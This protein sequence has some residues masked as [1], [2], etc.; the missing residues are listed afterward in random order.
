[1]WRYL[2]RLPLYDPANIVT[3]GEGGTPLI[4]GNADLGVRLFLKDETKNPTGSMKDRAMSAAYSKAKELGIRQSVIV[5]AGGAGIAASAYAS[6]A[7]IQNTILIPKGV[8]LERT[9]TMQIYGSELIEIDGNVED[10]LAAAARMVKELGAYDATTFRRGNPFTAEAPRTIAFELYEQ[11]GEVPDVV[12][13]PVGGGGTLAGIWRGYRELRELGLTSSVPR[14]IGVQNAKFN[15]LEIA[16]ARGY[17]TDE[18]LRTLDRDIDSLLPTTTGAIKH[19]YVP[20]GVEAL[21]A[22]RDTGG[23]VATATDEEAMEGQRWI[24]RSDGL[25]VEPSSAT[26]IIALQKLL[27]SGEI[28]PGQSVVLLLTGSGY[29]EMGLTQQFN[30]FRPATMTMDQ[31]FAHIAERYAKN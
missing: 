20:D 6:R 13:V 28:K 8:S 17:T 25:F 5:S 26:T 18:E 30:R 3:L 19:S 23:L 1:M 2:D 4:P 29:R 11:M 10:C 14:M 9:T 27:K 22:L 15:G 24:A 31:C 12:I 16:L 21:E 7:K